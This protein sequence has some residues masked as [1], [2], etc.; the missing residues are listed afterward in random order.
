MKAT[1]WVKNGRNSKKELKV[2]PNVS[3]NPAGQI[4]ESIWDDYVIVQFHTLEEDETKFMRVTMSP[5]EAEAL[6]SQLAKQ[7]KKFEAVEVSQ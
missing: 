3:G 5:K 6:M 1:N 7:L 4:G 2:W